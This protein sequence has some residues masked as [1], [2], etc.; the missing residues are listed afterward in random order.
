WYTSDVQVSW[1]VADD[2]SPLI[3]RTGCDTAAVTADTTGVTFT[4]TATS[5]GGSTTQSVTVKRDATAPELEFGAPAPAANAAGW[6][7]SDVS[8]PFTA[9]DVTSGI[10]STTPGSPVLITGVG[11]NLSADVTVTDN[12][13]N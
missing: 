11:A 3:D 6:Y 1:V 10:A 5:A 8:V 9:S 7:G 4:C 2:R 13:G 12:A